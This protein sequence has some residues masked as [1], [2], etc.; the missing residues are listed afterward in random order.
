MLNAHEDEAIILTPETADPVGFLSQS[1][2][3]SVGFSTQGES[4]DVS[5]SA[6]QGTHY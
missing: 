2:S 4:M 5:R 3:Y 1:R 6:P